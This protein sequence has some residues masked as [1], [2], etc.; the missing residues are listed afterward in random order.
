MNKPIYSFEKFLKMEMY[1]IVAV[2]DDVVVLQ[3]LSI[4]SLTYKMSMQELNNKY[5]WWLTCW[6]FT[7][8]QEYLNNE[9]EEDKEMFKIDRYF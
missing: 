6:D 8:N 4:P 3:D 5:L 2:Q 1:K 9:T 7:I